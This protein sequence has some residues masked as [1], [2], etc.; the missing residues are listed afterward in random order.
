MSCKGAFTGVGSKPRLDTGA[1]SDSTSGNNILGNRNNNSNNNG[2]VHN[3]TCHNA[4]PPVACRRLVWVPSCLFASHA[5]MYNDMLA[6]RTQR[7][8]NSCNHDS[9]LVNHVVGE[10]ILTNASR[11]SS[12]LTVQQN[13][14]KHSVGDDELY[15][16][17]K[18]IDTRTHNARKDVE[19]Q[20]SGVEVQLQNM[21]IDDP[22]CIGRQR[23]S[24]RVY[25]L[26]ART[27]PLL[28][29]YHDGYAQCASEYHNQLDGVATIFDQCVSDNA[30]E[31]RG[32]F[33]MTF[34]QLSEAMKQQHAGSAHDHHHDHENGVEE[35]LANYRTSDRDAHDDNYARDTFRHRIKS[36]I[37]DKENGE[38]HCLDDHRKT[39]R[40]SVHDGS[41]DM[42][43]DRVKTQIKETLRCVLVRAAGSLHGRNGQFCL[44][45]AGFLVDGKY[46]VHLAGLSSDP[47]LVIGVKVCVCVCVCVCELGFLCLWL[48]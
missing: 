1:Q 24:L 21:C 46:G 40:T 14:E 28:A 15:E 30:R 44:L 13:Q 39:C 47:A 35:H 9:W 33:V 11:N 10:D 12:C 37:N 34:D 19:Q 41:R 42:F 43:E 26:I 2:N 3:N 7:N 32:D 27:Q 25:V 17:P 16:R 45:E 18:L 31:E 36:R 8:D 22:L 4:N 23:I 20:G 6:R 5:H 29:F 48:V 38:E